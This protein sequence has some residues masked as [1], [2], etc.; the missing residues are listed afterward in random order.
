MDILA[1]LRSLLRFEKEVS[2]NGLGTFYKIKLPGRYDPDLQSYLPPRYDLGFR[3][4]QSDDSLLAD[5]ISS[6]ENLSLNTVIYHIEEYTNSIKSTLQSNRSF[7]LEGLGTISLNNNE[8]RFTQV[9]TVDL[10]SDFFGMPV[11]KEIPDALRERNSNLIPA[12]ENIIQL[13]QSDNLP[14][15]IPESQDEPLLNSTEK[16]DA[17]QTEPEDPLIIEIEKEEEIKQGI[18]VN[19]ITEEIAE[20]EEEIRKRSPLIR[21][22]II[23]FIILVAIAVV[24]M[25]KPSLFNKIV[26]KD[27]ALIATDT[28]INDSLKNP[29]DTLNGDS[30]LL[31]N[32]RA[33][34]QDSTNNGNATA[35]TMTFEIIVTAVKT[36]ND[37]DKYIARYNKLGFNGKAFTGK[38]LIRISVASFNS[39]RAAYDSLP[40]VKRILKDQSIYIQQNKI[41]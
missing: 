28:I 2:L 38:R 31:N 18:L 39:E 24:Y 36:Q 17:V 29:I 10:G 20:E 12:E 16:Y 40:S 9:D 26:G 19:E 5:L 30:A 35:D 1:H 11:L 23:L 8:M 41:K 6:K 21:W 33:A 3:A 13:D 34:V 25:A 14:A 27:Q 37:A 32:V 15:A 4:E 7:E 22:L